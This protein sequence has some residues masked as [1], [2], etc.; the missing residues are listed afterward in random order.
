MLQD[1]QLA[2]Y[3]SVLFLQEIK[4]F[5]VLRRYLSQF[6]SEVKKFVLIPWDSL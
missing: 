6:H 2:F 5:L 1:F 4:L 3:Q